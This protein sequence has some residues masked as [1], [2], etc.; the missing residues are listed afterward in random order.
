MRLYKWKR[1]P[2]GLASAQGVLQI[3]NG[4]D[5]VGTL[6]CSGI[7]IPGRQL[8]S[9]R[10][11]EEHLNCLDLLLGRLKD[12]G[13]KKRSSKCKFFQEKIH[14][15]GHIVSN[16]VVEVDPEKV[17]A[18]SKFKNPRTIEGY[19]R[20]SWFLRKT[21]TGY[22]KISGAALQAIKQKRTFSWSKECESAV[23]QLKQALREAPVLGFPKD[24]EACT[25]T[26]DAFLFGIGETISQRKQ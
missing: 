7:G 26:T 8:N 5:H 16:K 23:E 21:Y 18:A 2:L 9:G 4:I 22:W 17:A 15:L 12:A 1:L 13:L 11:L 10:S 25:L 19:I 3:F 14:I 6:L 24:T 20:N